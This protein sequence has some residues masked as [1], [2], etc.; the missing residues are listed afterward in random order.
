M[1][2][3]IIGATEYLVETRL[4]G[5]W[6]KH[7]VGVVSDNAIGNIVDDRRY[8]VLAWLYTDVSTFSKGQWRGKTYQ[9]DELNIAITVWYKV[10]LQCCRQLEVLPILVCGF[11]EIV[12]QSSVWEIVNY[13]LRGSIMLMQP[14][15][16]L[17]RGW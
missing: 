16:D 7:I 15:S 10:S 5:V 12:S 1:H 17:C 9:Q 6:G 2:D 8:L 13:R 11:Y 3:L 4:R 14:Y